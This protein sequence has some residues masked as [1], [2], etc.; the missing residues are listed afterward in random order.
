MDALC[1]DTIAFS[2]NEAIRRGARWPRNTSVAVLVLC[3][4][5]SLAGPAAITP[6]VRAGGAQA[7]LVWLRALLLLLQHGLDSKPE[8]RLFPPEAIRILVEG[9]D[10]ALRIGLCSQV[11]AGPPAGALA[12]FHTALAIFALG[13]A[14]PPTPACNRQPQPKP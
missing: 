10:G 12:G 11:C 8:D 4:C 7:P 6:L 5:V 1:I 13:I 2:A 3:R 9:C 14:C